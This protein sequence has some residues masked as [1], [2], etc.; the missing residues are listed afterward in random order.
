MKSLSPYPYTVTALMSSI[1]SDRCQTFHQDS[2]GPHRTTS[3][4][5][6][7]SRIDFPV[8]HRSLLHTLSIRKEPL[9]VFVNP[10]SWTIFRFEGKVVFTVLGTK[11][12]GTL[13]IFYLFRKCRPDG[14][15]LE[16]LGYR[17]LPRLRDEEKVCIQ[18]RIDE[19]QGKDRDK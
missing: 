3:D 2:T 10:S 4:L 18:V 14:F 17:S 12:N 6:V 15:Y 16:A 8:R 13:V 5:V 1:P 9:K 11:N 19:K 7:R